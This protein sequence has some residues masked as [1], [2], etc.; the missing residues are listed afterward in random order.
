MEKTQVTFV[1][2]SETKGALLFH[3]LDPQGQ[4]YARHWDGKI[5]MLYVRKRTFTQGWP[6]KISV[7][8]E[9]L[10]D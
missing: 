8:L 7:T 6:K 4:P 1:L 9:A 2:T 3:E 10:P 5:G